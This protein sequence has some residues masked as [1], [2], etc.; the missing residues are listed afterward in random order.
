MRRSSELALL[1]ILL[2]HITA[3]AN[4]DSSHIDQFENDLKEQ[5]EEYRDNK[6]EEKEKPMTIEPFCKNLSQNVTWWQ[7]TAAEIQ[8]IKN[9]GLGYSE[10]IKVILISKKIEKSSEDIIKRRNRGET[11]LKI[12]ERYGFD[13]GQIKNETKKIMSE[14]K[15]YETK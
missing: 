2:L 5:Q 13:Y 8:K 9:N 1:I 11:F 10:L 7:M 14:V 4:A 3:P 6:K 12:S 15:T